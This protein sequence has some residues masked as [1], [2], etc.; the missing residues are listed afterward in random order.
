LGLHLAYI[1][2]GNARIDDLSHAALTGLVKA[3]GERTT[4]EASGVRAV[5]PGQDDLV[6]YPFLYFPVRRDAAA[7]SA[8]ASNALNAYMASGGTVV[9]DTQPPT[10]D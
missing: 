1:E 8:Q 6:Y 3:L 7:L 4:I 5:V 2:T 10:P 9:F